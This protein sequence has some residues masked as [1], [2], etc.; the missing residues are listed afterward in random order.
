M[1]ADDSQLLEFP[2]DFPIKMM[3]KD[4]PAFHDAAR[5]IIEEHAGPIDENL[6]R[7][8]SSRNGRFISLTITIRAHS[9]QQL[10][11]IYVDLS[12]HDEILVAL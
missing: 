3:G 9:Q 7:A 10:D 6:M 11:A 8:A 4:H 2:C 1:A 12:A 5:A